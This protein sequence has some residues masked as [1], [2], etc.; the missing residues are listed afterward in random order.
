MQKFYDREKEIALLESIEEKS[1]KT[2]NL[3]KQL[4]GYSIEYCGF[5]L[6]DM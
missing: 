2:A 3:V 1:L 4:Q 5:S 6:E